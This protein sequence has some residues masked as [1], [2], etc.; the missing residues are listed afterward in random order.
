LINVQFRWS[1]M[2]P[3]ATLWNDRRGVTAIEYGLIAALI[4]VVIVAL[5]AGIGQSLNTIFSRV[6]ANLGVVG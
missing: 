6:N 5:L 1:V 2:K 3:A 4:A